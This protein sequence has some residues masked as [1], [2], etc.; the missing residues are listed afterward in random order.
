MT[1]YCDNMECI[2]RAYGNRCCKSSD[3]R[4][5]DLYE[6]GCEDYLD[7]MGAAD[8]QREYYK[9]VKDKDGNVYKR[10]SEGKRVEY[11]DLVLYTEDHPA[12][13]QFFTEE[14][15]G[16]WIG[17]L[18]VIKVKYDTI[19]EMIKDLPDVTGLPDEPEKRGEG[20]DEH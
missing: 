15:T 16:Y 5:G 4:V 3:I 17:N 2:H 14:K 1:V 9:C 11:K 19:I 10:K 8:Y 12:S 6:C 13:T 20:I 7:Y 18:D